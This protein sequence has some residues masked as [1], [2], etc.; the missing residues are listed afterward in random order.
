[1]RVIGLLGGMSWE[2]TVEYYSLLNRAARTA[3]WTALRAGSRS[4]AWTSR[5]SRP[6]SIRAT[7]TKPP[8]CWPTGRGGSNAGA[9]LALLCTNTMHKVFDQV[10]AAVD[11]PFLHLADATADRIKRDRRDRVGLLGTRF[12]MEQG[13]YRERLGAGSNA[14]VIVPD[15]EDRERVHQIIYDELCKGI[16]S[17]DSRS[18]LA[19]IMVRLGDRGAQAVVLGCTELGLLV[20]ELRPWPAGPRYDKDSRGG[21]DFP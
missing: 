1:M 18:S 13:F 4:T 6:H 21:G 9:E 15:E 8:G 19:D 20:G 2:S 17:D 10:Q 16:L 7:G 14:T 3:G 11:I 12:T 5:T